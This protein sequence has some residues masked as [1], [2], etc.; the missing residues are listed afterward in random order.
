MR[1]HDVGVAMAVLDPQC[2]LVSANPAALELLRRFALLT[3]SHATLPSSLAHE[4]AYAPIGEAI[5]WR[6]PND[7]TS[8]VLG[9][10]RYSLGT[11]HQLLLMREITEQQRALSRKIH[12]QRLE[13]T[14]RLISHIAHDLRAPL[15]S[16]IYSVDILAKGEHNEETR[17]IELAALALR[18][19][20]AG[21]LDFVRIGPP[22][23]VTQSLGRT[24][25]RISGLLR[26]AFRRGRH[27]LAIELHDD[28]VCVR[29]NTIALEQIFVN[30]LINATESRPDGVHVRVTSESAGPNV[31]VRVS[32]DGP[33]IP[34]DRRAS[35][36]DEFVTT[37]PNGTGLGL[38]V[39]REAAMSLGGHLEL[40]D[41]D[42]GCMFAVELPAVVA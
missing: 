12:R 5:M 6:H 40:V 38:T 15:S 32:D 2:G 30:L 41:S 1:L 39:A 7:E 22:V 34:K 17:T 21:L 33:G 8:A 37:K 31:I 19:T 14:G 9:C 27:E 24:F 28:A 42:L 18:D 11:E 4:L 35:I 25:E 16:I 29:G 23:N 36:F 20:I 13:A 26:P 3:D 10:T